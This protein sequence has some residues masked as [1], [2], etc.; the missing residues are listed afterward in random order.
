MF[1]HY[2]GQ[3]GGTESVLGK[4][5]ADGDPYRIRKIRRSFGMSL[6]QMRKGAMDGRVANAKWRTGDTGRY[7]SGDNDDLPAISPEGISAWS[8]SVAGFFV[9]TARISV[10]RAEAF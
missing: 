6:D 7:S 3:I 8:E 1:G 5:K 10:S 9:C 4:P 2:S